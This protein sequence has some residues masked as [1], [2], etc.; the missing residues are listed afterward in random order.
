MN[1][2]VVQ[3]YI[4]DGNWTEYFFYKIDNIMIELSIFV[5]AKKVRSPLHFILH[6]KDQDQQ[7]QQTLNMPT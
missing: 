3:F 1:Y 7:V 6:T 5:S 2:I 4:R